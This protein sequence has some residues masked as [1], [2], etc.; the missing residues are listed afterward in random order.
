MAYTTWGQPRTLDAQAAPILSPTTPF[1]TSPRRDL[2][3]TSSAS[4]QLCPPPLFFV[5]ASASPL[6]SPRPPPPPARATLKLP[7]HSSGNLPTCS[8]PHPLAFRC[9]S[10]CKINLLHCLPFSTSS[11]HISVSLTLRVRALT[12]HPSVLQDA[13]ANWSMCHCSRSA[14]RDTRRHAR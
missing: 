10:R 4:P 11:F 14:D 13:E 6:A 7:S 8:P 12:H 2:A 9:T 1:R 3:G 5:L